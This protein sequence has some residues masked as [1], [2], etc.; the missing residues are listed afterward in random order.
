MASVLIRRFWQ[1]RFKLSYTPYTWDTV[2]I[3]QK[4][5]EI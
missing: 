2:L 5:L 1:V 4:T 3:F